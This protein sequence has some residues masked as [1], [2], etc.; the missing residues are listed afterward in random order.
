MVTYNSIYSFDVFSRIDDGYQVYML[1]RQDNSVTL[2]NDLN[3]QMA[4]NIVNANNRA[5][6]YEFWVCEEREETVNEQ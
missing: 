3:A 6:R 5:R 2:V 4:I 1:D